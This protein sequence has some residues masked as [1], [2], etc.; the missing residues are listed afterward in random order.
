[1]SGAIEKGIGGFQGF[2]A[3]ALHTIGGS[4]PT[5]EKDAGRGAGTFDALLRW[6]IL[7]GEVQE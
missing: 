4:S 6:A 5:R 7:C 2:W 3:P 1:M